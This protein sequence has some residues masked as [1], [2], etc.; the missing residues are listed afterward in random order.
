[1]KKVKPPSKMTNMTN[2]EKMEAIHMLLV[3]GQKEEMAKEIDKW[4]CTF[5]EDYLYYLD[6]L[7]WMPS[8]IHNY[9]ARAVISYHKIK[10]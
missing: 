8:Q 9:F 4:G 6:P 5:W 10:K 1:M 3:N 7:Y 2:Q